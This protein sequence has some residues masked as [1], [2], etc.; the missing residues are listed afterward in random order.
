[1]RYTPDLLFQYDASIDY[2]IR[3]D[4]LLRDIKRD[5]DDHA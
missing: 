2:G 5:E 1:M 3:I 4:S